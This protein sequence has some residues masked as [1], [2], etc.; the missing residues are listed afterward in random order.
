MCQVRVKR[1]LAEDKISGTGRPDLGK[2][3]SRE[4]GRELN[5]KGDLD[6]GPSRLAGWATMGLIVF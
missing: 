2:E 4:V 1:N 3:A 6:W 5:F